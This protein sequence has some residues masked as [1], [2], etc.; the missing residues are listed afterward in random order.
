MHKLGLCIKAY[1]MEIYCL[2]YAYV[3]ICDME[4]SKNSKLE[5]KITQI[6]LCYM[7]LARGLDD[8]L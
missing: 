7:Q 1:K 3:E 4:K 6:N 2:I 5:T 8:V